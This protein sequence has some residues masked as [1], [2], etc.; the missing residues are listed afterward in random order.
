MISGGPNSVNDEDA[1]IYDPDI[2]NLELP[3]LGICYGMQLIN[4]HYGGTVGK[5]G[6]RED[7]QFTISV[8]TGEDNMFYILIVYS[9]LKHPL[10]LITYCIVVP[11]EFIIAK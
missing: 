10:T 2:F 1:P 4:V 9:V 11:I 7:G 6:V 5:K 3:I 8:E